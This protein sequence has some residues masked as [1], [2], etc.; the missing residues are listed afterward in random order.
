MLMLTK[1]SL[2][3]RLASD[4]QLGR[5][6]KEPHRPSIEGVLSLAEE[7]RREGRGGRGG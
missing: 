3:L 7:K 6:A 5:E 2:D 1:Y 4:L